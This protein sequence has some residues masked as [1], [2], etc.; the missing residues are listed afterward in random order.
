VDQF[1]HQCHAD[2]PERSGGCDRASSLNHDGRTDEA[3]PGGGGG[4]RQLGSDA[5]SNPRSNVAQV[6]CNNTGE[7]DPYEPFV[8]YPMYTRTPVRLTCI[9]G[10][11]P[12]SNPTSWELGPPVS[13]MPMRD[14]NLTLTQQNDGPSFVLPGHK[15]QWRA[16]MW[17]QNNDFRLRMGYRDVK[18]AWEGSVADGPI[19][20]SFSNAV[21]DS[22]LFLCHTAFDWTVPDS[23]DGNF[24]SSEIKVWSVAAARTPALTVVDTAQ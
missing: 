16:Q 18:F 22:P 11:K 4:A 14:R 12:K 6:C 24:T 17:D 8:C 5:C 3:A 10:N 7:H 15:W 9:S 23:I 20:F 2:A 13:Y 1:S 21:A 19:S